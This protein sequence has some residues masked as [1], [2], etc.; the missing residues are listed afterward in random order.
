LHRQPLLEVLADYEVRHPDEASCARRIRALVMQHRNCFDRDCLPG[1]VTASAWILSH[2]RKRFLLT[3]HRKLQ[4]WLQLGG[5][6][7]GDP[8]VR[9]VALREAREESGMQDFEFL[10][11]VPFDLDVHLIP[12]RRSEPEHEHH[13]IRFLLVASGAEELKVSTESLDLRWFDCASHAQVLDDES[14]RRLG[15]KAA[16]IAAMGV[17]GADTRPIG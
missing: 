12:A 5:H 2:D 4:R 8:D 1:H 3:P 15:R 16:K 14:T 17:S 10:E 9:A 11:D 7:D 6:A 13:D